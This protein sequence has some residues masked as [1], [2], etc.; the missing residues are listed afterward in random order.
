MKRFQTLLACVALIVIAT[1]CAS[2]R[3]Y[4]LPTATFQAQRSSATISAPMIYVA[5]TFSSNGSHGSF[6]GFA[7][8]AN[9]NVPPVVKILGKHTEVGEWGGVDTSVAVD[10][11]G[12]FYINSGYE[13]TVG[14]W[15]AGSNG[16]VKSATS[17]DVDC[18]DFTSEPVVIV[19]DDTGH[20]WYSCFQGSGGAGGIATSAIYELPRI[21][22]N[23][24]GYNRIRPIRQINGPNTGLNA[25]SSIAL[26]PKGEV[27][28]EEYSGAIQTF[29]AT[30]KGDV[31]PLYTLSGYKTRLGDAGGIRYDSRGRLLACSN[32]HRAR[33]LTFAP[34]ARGNVAPI[35]SLFV[36]GCSGITLDSRDNIYIVSA[37]SI[38][39]YAARATGSANPIRVISG[40]LTGLTNAWTIALGR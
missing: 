12:R 9:G 25:I 18:D 36:P 21:P 19:L 24:A 3:A 14:V 37:T 26:N 4:D 1:A 8:D 10:K 17:F 7:N 28:V 33:I 32:K 38:M 16:D 39:E 35:S 20:I 40:D 31:P 11:R 23:A 5:N 34:G 22:T 29:A 6:L 27:S 30:A 13:D 15:P 2:S